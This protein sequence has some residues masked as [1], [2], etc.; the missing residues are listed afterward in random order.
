[1][2]TKQQKEEAVKEGVKK[3]SSAGSAIFAD[4]S[5]TKV[6]NIRSLKKSLKEAEAEFGVI[7][8]RLLKIILKEN[9]IY[10]DPT[11]YEAQVG[12]ILAQGD[13]SSAAGKAYKFSKEFESFK[14]LGGLD[15]VKKEAID[16]NTVKAI[17]QLP[18][19]EILL[20]QFLGVLTA[21]L[22]MFMYILQ[23]KSK[24]TQ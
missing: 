15:L 24:Q 22:R 11:S 7:K 20:A 13:I 12:T 5:G 23:E 21:P 8:K 19:K 10:F 2:K 3:F 18:S 17:G 4:F 1:M 14:I 16:A 9:G 6:E